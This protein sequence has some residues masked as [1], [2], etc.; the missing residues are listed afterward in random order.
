MACLHAKRGAILLQQGRTSVSKL[1]R[2]SAAAINFCLYQHAQNMIAP[3]GS[4]I[5]RTKSAV[6]PLGRVTGASLSCAKWWGQRTP[7]TNR[8]KYGVLALARK[9]LCVTTFTMHLAWSA[10]SG[11]ERRGGAGCVVRTAQ[12]IRIPRTGSW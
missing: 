5:D 7:H 11:V 2:L 1:F 9:V 6:V 10:G 3:E 12:R 4:L 8:N